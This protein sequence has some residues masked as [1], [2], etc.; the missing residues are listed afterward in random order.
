M[1]F[2]YRYKFTKKG[3]LKGTF[4][5]NFPKNILSFCGVDKEIVDKSVPH[6]KYPK[7]QNFQWK[8]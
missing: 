3:P 4:T 7:I 1:P 2:Y 5:G 6:I 8:P